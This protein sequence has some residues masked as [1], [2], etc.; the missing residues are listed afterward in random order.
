MSSAYRRYRYSL[1]SNEVR[2]RNAMRCPVKRSCTGR[3]VS[4][5]E[6][7]LHFTVSPILRFIFNPSPARQC[8]FPLFLGICLSLTGVLFLA[9]CFLFLVSY[10][11]LLVSYFLLL[12]SY[13]LLLVSCILL[14]TSCILLLTSCILLL[15]LLH[16]TSYLLHLTSFFLPLTS[17]FF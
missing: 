2:E 14:L 17:C 6:C 10:F 4:S 15:N 9:S 12:V 16:L 3:I 5:T 11:L 8:H 13:F 7:V 1:E